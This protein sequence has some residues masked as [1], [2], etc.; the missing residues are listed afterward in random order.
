MKIVPLL[1][2]LCVLEAAKHTRLRTR[3][4]RYFLKRV[5][6]VWRECWIVPASTSSNAVIFKDILRDGIFK[7]TPRKT[8]QHVLLAALDP[9]RD[10][11]PSRTR[12]SYATGSRH[13]AQT[14]ITVNVC[15]MNHCFEDLAL[16]TKRSTLRRLNDRT[17]R[18]L[19][20][21]SRK[22]RST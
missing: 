15:M 10:V 5:S 16:R 14:N 6:E 18:S 2:P 22:T 17:I 12:S 21:W 1:P 11:L 4:L 13:K 19:D 3:S 7:A 20:V 9:H 8:L